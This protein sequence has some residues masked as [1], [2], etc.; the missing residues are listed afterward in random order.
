MTSNWTYSEDDAAALYDILNPWSPIDD[1]YLALAMAAPT[2]LDVGCGTGRLLHRARSAGHT[3]RLVGID[4]DRAVLDIA[5]RRDDVEWLNIPAAAMSFDREFDLAIMMSNAFQCL[6]TDDDVRASLAAIHRALVV[7]GR[8]VF[9]TRNPALRAWEGWHPGNPIDVVD[10]AGR[11]VRVSYEVL[12]VLGDVV[13]T[14][15]TTSDPDGTILRVDRGDIRFLGAAA[16]SAFLVEAGFEVEAQH[17]D[18]HGEP[19][20]ASSAEIVTHARRA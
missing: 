7:G 8:F 3:G 4:P 15:E 18:W 5:R 16:V 10:P 6:T 17:G 14:T 19:L 20:T 1:V 9:E 11:A 12:S 13:A 2:V